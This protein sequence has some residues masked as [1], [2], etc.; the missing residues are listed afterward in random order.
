MNPPKNIN[1]LFE[2]YP[3]LPQILP[4]DYSFWP[5]DHKDD[6]E[7][8]YVLPPSALA[9]KSDDNSYDSNCPK[10]KKHS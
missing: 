8:D 6:M 4:D 1:V 9:W 10:D 7:N 3:E 2:F 5:L